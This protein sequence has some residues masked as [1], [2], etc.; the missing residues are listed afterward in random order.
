MP[1][2]TGLTSLLRGTLAGYTGNAPVPFL[3]QRSVLLSYSY[4]IFTTIISTRNTEID[5]TL[6]IELSLRL[7]ESPVQ[8]I[9]YVAIKAEAVEVESTTVFKPPQ[10]SRLL[11][12]PMSVLPLRAW[13]WSRTMSL[14]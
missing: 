12:T 7:S 9:Y 6:R 1:E 14:L 3:R 10:F 5:A 13:S 4:P 11:D 2:L 8:P